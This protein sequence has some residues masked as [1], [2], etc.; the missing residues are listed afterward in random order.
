MVVTDWSMPGMTGLE[1]LRAIRKEPD[2]Q[3][4]PVLLITAEARKENILAAAHS[5]ASS[6]MV[7]PFTMVTLGKKIEGVLQRNQ[8]DSVTAES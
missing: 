5:G 3:H 1:L 4:L 7:K 2:L 6:Y 8:D